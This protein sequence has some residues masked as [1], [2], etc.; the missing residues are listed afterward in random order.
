MVSQRLALVRFH[1][2]ALVRFRRPDSRMSRRTRHLA[3][4]PATFGAA[5]A[6]RVVPDIV[7]SASKMRVKCAFGA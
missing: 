1:G 6:A 3:R 4:A 2:L 5:G 7:H